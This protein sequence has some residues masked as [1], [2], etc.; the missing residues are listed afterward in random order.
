[1]TQIIR[2]PCPAPCPISGNPCK[3]RGDMGDIP[4]YYYPAD[5]PDWNECRQTALILNPC[6]CTLY[7]D[8]ECDGDCDY[9]RG[10]DYD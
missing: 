2:I 4:F 10:N 1:M 9:I 7:P 6:P 5:C 8:T 3:T